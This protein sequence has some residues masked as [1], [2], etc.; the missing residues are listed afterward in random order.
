VACSM[1]ADADEC[2]S[3][4]WLDGSA[5]VLDVVDEASRDSGICLMDATSAD[6]D[7][8]HDFSVSTVTLSMQIS[9]LL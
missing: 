8:Y 7:S 1:W 2:V 4:G 5:P 6:D 9:E 3:T